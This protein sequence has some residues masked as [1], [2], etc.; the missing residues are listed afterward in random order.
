MSAPPP[1]L[2]SWREIPLLHNLTPEER[3][4]LATAA[5]AVV[6]QPGDY[7][8]RQG[9]AS[10]DLWIVLDG[11][12]QVLRDPGGGTTPVV[13]AQLRP[14]AHFGEMSFFHAAPHS[15]SVRAESAVRLLRI[16]RGAFNGL[17]ERR[18]ALAYKLAYNTIEGLAERLRRTSQRLTDIQCALESQ[19]LAE[20]QREPA[21]EWSRFR[22]KLFDDWN[23]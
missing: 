23:L 21:S 12:C 15:A 20:R 17:L 3:D 5:R 14:W 16:E 6:A 18:P 7:I 10:R 11:T 8:L 4:E 19:A 13:L 1:D 2:A 22:G 9:D